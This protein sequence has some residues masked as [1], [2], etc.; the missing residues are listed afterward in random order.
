MVFP[1]GGGSS[2]IGLCSSP[3]L[4]EMFNLTGIFCKWVETTNR[5]LFLFGRVVCCLV[6][7]S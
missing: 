2:N 4:E 6:V 3:Y 1:L 5:F 7:F